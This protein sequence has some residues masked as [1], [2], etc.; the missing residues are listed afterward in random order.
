MTAPG[1]FLL[2]LDTPRGIRPETPTKDSDRVTNHGDYFTIDVAGLSA[3]LVAS[4]QAHQRVMWSM[5]QREW[6]EFWLA[7]DNQARSDW[8]DARCYP[9]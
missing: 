7:L 2:A 6:T 4:L 9:V 3:E 5:G 8:L 1:Q